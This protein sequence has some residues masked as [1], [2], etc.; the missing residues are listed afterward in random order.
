ML[1]ESGQEVSHP[2]RGHRRSLAPR[3]PK[4]S[5]HFADLREP[6]PLPSTRKALSVTFRA[7]L[8]SLPCASHPDHRGAAWF[9]HLHHRAVAI[10]GSSRRRRRPWPF[11]AALETVIIFLGVITIAT[12]VAITVCTAAPL[13]ICSTAPVTIC[14]TTPVAICPTAPVAICP[15]TT[16]VTISTAVPLRT[17]TF[18]VAVAAASLC[19]AVSATLLTFMV[20]ATGVRTRSSHV[21]KITVI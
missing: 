10:C 21:F 12:A 14:S 17:A 11:H 2:S 7:A 13:A 5:L 20:V 3:C 19:V 15:T 9:L 8:V 18:P 16:P 1:W 6:T 4:L